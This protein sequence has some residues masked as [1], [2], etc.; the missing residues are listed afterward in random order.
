MTTTSPEIQL[1]PIAVKKPTLAIQMIANFF[2]GKLD[3][4]FGYAQRKQHGFRGA[5]P[6]RASVREE[7]AAV[8]KMKLKPRQVGKKP[9]S[10]RDLHR[11]EVKY[12]MRL[13]GRSVLEIAR[14]DFVLA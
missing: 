2:G 5:T 9:L 11:L 10:T 7:R 14:N 4:F 1:H 8:A 13:P 3:A 12:D 6:S